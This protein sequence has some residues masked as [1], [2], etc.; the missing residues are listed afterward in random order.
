MLY[1]V[2]FLALAGHVFLWAGVVNRLHAI[3]LPRWA[4]DA[5]LVLSA[6]AGATIPVA[7]LVACV[8]GRLRLLDPSSRGPEFSV[9]MVYA[10]ICLVALTATAVRW[11]GRH[12]RHRAPDVLRRHGSRIVALKPATEDDEHHF[13]AR[14]PGNE[15][16]QLDVTDRGVELPRMPAGLEGLTI[17]HLSDLHFTGRVGKGYFQEVVRLSNEAEPDLVAITGDLVDFDE[18]IDW[19]PGTLGRLSARYGVYFILGNHDLEVDTA[20][21]RSVLTG[22]GLFDLGGRWVEI[23]LRGERVVLA[24]NELPWIAP[25]AD[26]RNAPPPRPD[27]PLRILLAHTPDQLGWARAHDVDLMFAG[28]THG[29]QIRI[30]V[31]GPLLSPSLKGVTYASGLFYAPPTVMQVSRGV[32]G[33]FPLRVNCAPEMIRTVL[34]A[35]S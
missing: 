3:A 26:L 13:L 16:L 1:L 5:I 28:H 35:R 9:A 21:L 23:S 2:L 24:G 18:C 29:G 14:M 31:L 27:G 6:V 10:A 20:R 15:V 12:I 22:C 4:S 8:Q 11:F 32:S 7:Y 19:M 34:H 30:P 33:L 25:A 17:I